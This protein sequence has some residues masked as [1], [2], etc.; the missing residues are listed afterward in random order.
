[1]SIKRSK[2]ESSGRR[3]YGIN[4]GKR[5]AKASATRQKLID[6]GR[7]LFAEHGYHGTGTTEIVAQSGVTQG[8]LYH[9]F[10]DK[11]DLFLAVFMDVQ[12]DLPRITQASVEP[13][14]N[15]SNPWS[16][17]REG[18]STFLNVIVNHRDLQRILL[19]DGPAVLGWKRWREIQQSYGLGVI[20]DAV[21]AS[22]AAGILPALP[23]KQLSH[24]ILAASD[25]A[26]LLIV[27]GE[28]Q[29][30]AIKRIAATMDALLAGLAAPESR[31]PAVGRARR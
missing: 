11:E 12:R 1:V 7:K 16:A 8:A 24:M 31:R 5:W 6:T 10:A 13:S 29:P 18:V 28:G 4:K 14:I 17:F 2:S 25:E 23:A 19:V 27:N 26:A 3:K 9:H 21:E 30:A 20:S 15:E 22:I